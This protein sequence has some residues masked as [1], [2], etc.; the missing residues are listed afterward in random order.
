MQKLIQS[1][2]M[3]VFGIISLLLTQIN[4][5]FLQNESKIKTNFA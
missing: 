3:Q 2:R 5:E 1:D 4:K